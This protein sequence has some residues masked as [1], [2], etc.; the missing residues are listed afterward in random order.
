MGRNVRG[1]NIVRTHDGCE[2]TMMRVE[3]D[4][5]ELWYVQ[6]ESERASMFVQ[7]EAES[8]PVCT[9]ISVA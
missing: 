2:R 4:E 7:R 6:S 3:L 1:G 5:R 9:C 8:A